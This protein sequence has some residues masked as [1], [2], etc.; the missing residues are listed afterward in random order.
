MTY[1]KSLLVGLAGAIVGAVLWLM[2]EFAIA[3]VELSRQMASSAGSGGIG[4]V[5]VASYSFAGALV[6]FVGGFLWNV[7]RLKKLA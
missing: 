4:A 3:A 7:R 5:T 1:F 2:A 6:G